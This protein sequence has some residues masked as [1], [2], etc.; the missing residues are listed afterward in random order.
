MDCPF[1]KIVIEN[2]ERII[3]ETERTFTV[4]SKPRLM[5]GHLLVIPKKHVERFSE[6]SK[7]ERNELFDEIALLEQKIL[8]GLAPGCDISQHYRPFIPNSRFKVSHLHIH[9]RPRS[10]DDDLYQKVQIFERDVFQ[11]PNQEEFEKFK[12]LFGN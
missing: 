6:L 12:K 7:E 2:T 8:I 5:P 10:L 3:R 11:E 1:C 9:V 4:L